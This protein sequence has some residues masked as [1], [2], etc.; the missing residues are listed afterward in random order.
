M[1]PVSNG[2]VGRYDIRRGAVVETTIRDN[3]VATAKIPDLAV[4]FPDKIDDPFWNHAEYKTLAHNSTVTTTLGSLGALSF[5]VPAWV[6]SVTVFAVGNFQVSNSSGGTISAF[7][8]IEILDDVPGV[9]TTTVPN[10]QTAIIPIHRAASFVGVAGS[11]LEVDLS[12]SVST[13]SNSTNF[14]TLQISVIGTR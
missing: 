5:D 10:N 8:R 3:A 1:A 9:Y 14:G 7:A 4:T 2:Q 12:A 6:D 13:G 11:T